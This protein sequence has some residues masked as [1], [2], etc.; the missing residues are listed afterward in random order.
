MPVYLKLH[1]LQIYRDILGPI[2]CT[3]VNHVE[4]YIY[5][6]T[7]ILKEQIEAQLQSPD[8]HSVLDINCVNKYRYIVFTRSTSALEYGGPGLP[9]KILQFFIRL[10]LKLRKK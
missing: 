5:Q 4:M 10:D 2:K 6:Y 8:F 7:K 1:N 9:L 3:N